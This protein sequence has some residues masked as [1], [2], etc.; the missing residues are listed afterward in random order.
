M[1]LFQPL[2]TDSGEFT[3]PM[4]RQMG[5]AL[6]PVQPENGTLSL[7]RFPSNEHEKMTMVAES[8]YKILHEDLV[9]ALSGTTPLRTEMANLMEF[10]SQI[11]YHS[12]NSS[13]SSGLAQQQKFPNEEV[14]NLLNSIARVNLEIDVVHKGGSLVQRPKPPALTAIF[15]LSSSHYKTKFCFREFKSHIFFKGHA[16]C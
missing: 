10:V 2:D 3:C 8:F 11:H 4:C 14:I 5:N 7:I 16:S 1:H 12:N 15:G 9:G 6:L 13:S